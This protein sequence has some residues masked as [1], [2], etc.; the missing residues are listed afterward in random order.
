MRSAYGKLLYLLQDSTSPDIQELLGF[1][2]VRKMKTVHSVLA[3]YGALDALRDELMVL[4]TSEIKPEGKTRPQIDHELKRKERA[5]EI[6]G[7]RYARPGLKAEDLKQCILAI[8][9]NHNY[10]RF[11]RD[12]VDAII[13]YLTTM[14]AP[15]TFEPGYSL[16]IVGGRNGARLT[17]THQTQYEYVLQTL[18]LWREILHDMYRL[19]YLAEEDL[20]DSESPYRLRDTGQGLNRVQSCPRIGRAMSTIIHRVHRVIGAWVGSS[21]VHLGDENVPNAFM[22]IESFS[23]PLLSSLS[24]H[25]RLG[26]RGIPDI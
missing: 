10:L 9:D 11:N 24:S 13:H 3:H 23:P 20:L 19:W 2:I 8:G 21:V 17:H 6:L 14:F 16:A 7:D 4:A 18:T 5:L 26:V 1:N 25:C 12:S 15:E 22:V